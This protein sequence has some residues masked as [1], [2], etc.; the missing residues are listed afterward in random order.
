MDILQGGQYRRLM[1]WQLTG[2]LKKCILFQSMKKGDYSSAIHDRIK[3][4]KAGSVFAM[5][6]FADLAPNNAANR[7]VTR[8]VAEGVLTPVLRGIYQKPKYSALLG[9]HVLPYVEDVAAALARKCGWTIRADGDTALNQLGLSTQVPANWVYLSDGPYRKYAFL[10]GTIVF[11]HSAN[12]L[13]GNLSRETALVVQALR[14][15]GREHLTNETLRR[16]AERFDEK[17]W[18]I[19]ER[20]SIRASDWIREAISHVREIRHE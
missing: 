13:L 9:E 15:L 12:R 19:I 7:V 18:K 4:A 3:R 20:E 10:R 1:S 14:A 6:D 11:K 16:L 17:T 5:V 2:R 8:L